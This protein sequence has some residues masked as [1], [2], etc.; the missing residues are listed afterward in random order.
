M[1]KKSQ[2]R[3]DEEAPPTTSLHEEIKDKRKLEQ[4]DFQTNKKLKMDISEQVE[5]DSENEEIMD[6]SESESEESETE[7]SVIMAAKNLHTNDAVFT[8]FFQDAKQNETNFEDEEISSTSD[9]N[10]EN[11]V[12]DDDDDEQQDDN[13]S[14]DEQVGLDDLIQSVK[15]QHKDVN[16]RPDLSALYQLKDTKD[17][18]ASTSTASLERSTAYEVLQDGLK[19]WEPIEDYLSMSRTIPISYDENV[20]ERSVPTA[21]SESIPSTSFD[22]QLQEKLL[23][24]K[25]TDKDESS[26]PLYAVDQRTKAT[27]ITKMDKAELVQ[28]SREIAHQ[29]AQLTFQQQ[30]QARLKKIKSKTYRKIMKRQKAREQE[31]IDEEIKELDPEQAKE[32]LLQQEKDYIKERVT[33]RHKNSSAWVRQSMK[34]GTA[35]YNKDVGLSVAEQLK[36]GDDLR[37]KQFKQVD[38]AEEI[39]DRIA[40][41]SHTEVL[42]QLKEEIMEEKEMNKGLYNMKFMKQARERKLL[43]SLDLIEQIRKDVEATDENDDQSELVTG[44]VTF[45]S[46]S[47]SSNSSKKKSVPVNLEAQP[48]TVSIQGHLTVEDV[49]EVTSISHAV[50]LKKKNPVNMTPVTTTLNK[51]KRLEAPTANPWLQKQDSDSVPVKE[52]RASKKMKKDEIENE[53]QVK[54][55][56]ITNDEKTPTNN[57]NEELD[58]IK[59][60]A[61]SSDDLSLQFQES[62]S[63]AIQDEVNLPEMESASKPG[64]GSWAGKGTDWR[65]L[66]IEK[67]NNVK[68]VKNKLILQK[69]AERPDADIGHVIIRETARVPDKYLNQNVRQDSAMS[70]IHDLSMAH[71]LGPEWNSLS[72]HLQANQPRIKVRPGEKILPLSYDTAKLDVNKGRMVDAR[73]RHGEMSRKQLDK[74]VDNRNV[75]GATKIQ[76]VIRE[77][78]IREKKNKDKPTPSIEFNHDIDVIV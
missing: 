46:S 74:E 13:D 23:Q 14:A 56:N 39:A 21:S 19:K 12:D 32:K 76:K 60:Q 29:R 33:Q 41:G 38:D 72:G 47:S 3:V 42:D 26:L 59:R 52:Q 40:D 4:Q 18:H 68:R 51:R 45:K 55:K 30:K 71:P 43:E 66:K 20:K 27:S 11:N 31:A 75:L 78:K 5:Q 16:K 62:K 54:I 48:T 8:G 67:E 57:I 7:V 37:R 1:G 73:N 70:Q 10:E 24:N 65:A 58:Q 9:A 36:I 35:H 2:K 63:R 44:R 77:K 69:A 50:T 53:S 64:W 22:H 17:Y 34:S 49:P 25:S 15:E 61:F 28:R 6:E